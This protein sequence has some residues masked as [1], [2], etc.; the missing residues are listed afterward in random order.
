MS[1]LHAE[2]APR[3]RV[4]SRFTEAEVDPADVVTFPDG[5]PGYEGW[6]QFVLVDVADIAPLRI[7]H[8]VNSDEPCFLVV[9]PRTVLPSYRYSF[10]AAD[11]LRLGTKDE[12]SLVWLAIVNVQEGGDIAVNLRAPVVIDPVRMV[13]RQVMPNDSLYPLQYLVGPEAQA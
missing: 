8:A 5:I 6:R 12:Q 9:D 13:G 11:R 4:R 7:L 1:A 10:G 3:L 2:A